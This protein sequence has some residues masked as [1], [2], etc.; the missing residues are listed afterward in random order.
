M[1]H[2]SFIIRPGPCIKKVMRVST[3]FRFKIQFH[4]NF[5]YQDQNKPD[6]TNF[7]TIKKCFNIFYCFLS[8]LNS[9]PCGNASVWL[10]VAKRLVNVPSSPLKFYHRLLSTIL[11]AISS[12]AFDPFWT[13]EWSYYVKILTFLF[14]DIF[15]ENKWFSI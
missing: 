6:I 3:R 1:H 14:Y 15:V 4:C 10:I 2:E 7:H 9:L 8:K 12:W 11:T 13:T 5:F